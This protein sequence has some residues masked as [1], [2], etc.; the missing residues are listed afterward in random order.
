MIIL[1]RQFVM[2]MPMQKKQYRQANLQ[3]GTPAWLWIDED[4]INGYDPITVYDVTVDYRNDVP[5]LLMTL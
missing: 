1:K 2:S 5:T 3:Q 4:G